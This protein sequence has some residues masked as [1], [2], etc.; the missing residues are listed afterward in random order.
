MNITSI[1]LA[2]IAGP[3]DTLLVP[4][5][6]L[7]E[8]RAAGAG[9]TIAV[10]LSG[11]GNWAAFAKGLTRE[12][13]AAGISVVGL[14]SR[15]YLNASPRKTP[16]IA[17]RDLERLLLAYVPAW[18]ADSVV[19]I[20]YSRG[21]DIAP[22]MITRLPREWRGR[23]P[24]LVLLSPS[25]FASFEFHLIDLVSD[26][27]RPTDIPLLPV[28]KGLQGLPMLCVYG[29]DDPGALCP[30]APPELMKIVAL[31]QGHRMEDPEGVSALILQALH[32]R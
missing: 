17:S 6:P 18:K 3:P 8:A 4:D 14:K 11:D 26:K 25:R 1:A 7:V 27:R 2:L 32:R 28:V 19:L 31:R 13:N 24:L 30:L 20:G 9:G 10:L 22:F 5:L 12:L 29:S 15:S 23:I 16:D 21:A